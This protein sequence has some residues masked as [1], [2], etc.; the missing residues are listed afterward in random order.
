MKTQ[1]GLKKLKV[2]EMSFSGIPILNTRNVWKT[3]IRK[4]V[5]EM[6]VNVAK[7]VTTSKIFPSFGFSGKQQANTLFQAI[8]SSVTHHVQLFVTPQT[9]ANQAYLSSPSPKVCQ[10]YYCSMPY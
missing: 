4:R 1:F 8:T 3:G 2:C 7:E 6:G 5:I 10:S 9:A